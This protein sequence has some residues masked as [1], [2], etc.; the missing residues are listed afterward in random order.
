[1]RSAPLGPGQSRTF[2]LTFESISAQWNR[3]YPEI[4]ISDVSVK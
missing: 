1:L 4:K 2:R 3:Q